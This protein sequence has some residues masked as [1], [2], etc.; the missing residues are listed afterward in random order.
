MSEEININGYVTVK[1][2]NKTIIDKSKNK[3]TENMI[4]GLIKCYSNTNGVFRGSQWWDGGNG[5]IGLGYGGNSETYKTMTELNESYSITP[6][7]ISYYGIETGDWYGKI[8]FTATY[9]S[10]NLVENN[11]TDV[12]EI[13]LFLKPNT[14]NWDNPGSFG[15]SSPSLV[16]CA[17]ISEADGNLNPVQ[18]D[19]SKPLTVEWIY[20][21]VV[22]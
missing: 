16:L 11:V 13:G 3:F 12:N 15:T 4:K 1:Q 10:D 7:N 17:R 2:E 5:Y 19:Q 20:E 18:V 21:L 22:E 6:D 8:K 9:N 14:G